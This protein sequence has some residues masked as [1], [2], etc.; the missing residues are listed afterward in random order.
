MFQSIQ[1][2]SMKNFKYMKTFYKKI[3][4]KAKL[5]LN[6]YVLIP[7]VYSWTAKLNI[8][9]DIESIQYVIEHHC[10]LSRFGDGEFDIIKGHGNG[11][12]SPDDRLAKR[13]MSF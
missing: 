2:E 10:S 6:R 8:L 3:R 5:C 1:G 13:L 12:Q 9:P 4:H 7:F 11:F